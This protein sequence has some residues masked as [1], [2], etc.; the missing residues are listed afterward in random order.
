MDGVHLLDLIGRYDL[1]ID[2][3]QELNKKYPDEGRIWLEMG[4]LKSA[5][6]NA[7]SLKTSSQYL[8]KAIELG[9]NLP[10]TYNQLGLVYFNLGQFSKAKNA[11][12]Q[13]L[14]SDP[15]NQNAKDYLKQ[16]EALNL[17]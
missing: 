17:P 16:Y 3:C 8:E 13:A 15:D 9:E 2:W 6:N 10:A 7:E 11:W 5:E 1:A 12:Q 4:Y 14:N